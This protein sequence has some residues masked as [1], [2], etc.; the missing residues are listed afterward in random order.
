[1]KSISTCEIYQ[2]CKFEVIVSLF[3]ER[4]LIEGGMG[5]WIK[6]GGREKDRKRETNRYS[7]YILIYYIYVLYTFYDILWKI[8]Q[9]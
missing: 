8:P 2:I 1:M 3:L 6:T 4:G 5:I 9:G 7:K